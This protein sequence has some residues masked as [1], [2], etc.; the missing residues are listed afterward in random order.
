MAY[1]ILGTPKPAF[2]DSSGSPLVSGTITIQNPSDSAVKAS[3]PT[4]DDADASTN[5]T[6]G[7][8][9]LDS[10]GEPT[11]TQLWG[12]D[13]EDYKIIIKDSDAATIYTMDKIRLATA[14]RR[15]TV[16]FTSGDDTPSIAES[17][18]F[19]LAGTTTITDFDNG[20]VGDII[21]ILATGSALTITHNAN[22]ILKGR[23]SWTMQSGESLTLVMWSDQIWN[24]IGRSG[25]IR[26]TVFKLAD[27]SLISST[28][29]DDT[30]FVDWVLQPNTF[31]KLDG[32]LKVSADAGSRD[33][34]IDFTTDNAFVEECYS[35]IT[36]DAGT[37]LTVDEGETQALT[38]AVAVIDIDGTGL[39]G[40]ILKGFVLT[41]ATL[42]C[43]VDV[44]FANQAGAGTVTVAKGSWIT[45]DPIVY[46]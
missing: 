18:T 33:L 37:A 30:H 11:S 31:Y 34:E 36:V 44:Q 3:Y 13:N 14:N 7:D 27:E 5:G 40:I 22:I 1:P 46:S 16:T 15:A 28:L 42:Q 4:A 41:H 43:T 21:H 20:E 45:F 24:E 6:S 32:Y 9:T 10:R 12:K 38:T 2:F 23:R 26:N 35:F 29:A 8:I 19:K 17:E 39:V 25:A